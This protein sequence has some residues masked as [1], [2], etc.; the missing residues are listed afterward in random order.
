MEEEV[1]AQATVTDVVGEDARQHD[2]EHRRRAGRTDASAVVAMAR[3][4]IGPRVIAMHMGIST[5]MVRRIL[6]RR[7]L[8]TLAYELATGWPTL[9][10]EGQR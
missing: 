3:A 10:R 6:H 2:S 9:A 8:E 5:R 4:G 7:V 1:R